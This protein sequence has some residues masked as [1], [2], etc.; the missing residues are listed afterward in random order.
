MD[1]NQINKIYCI[2]I[3]GIGI[4]AA[5]RIL[6]FQ[7]KEVR[8]SDGQA[9]EITDQLQQEGVE[10][11]IGQ[12]VDDL[13][14]E[15]DL[16]VYSVAVP[17]THPQRVKA[18]EIGIRQIT[19]PQLLGL[20]MKDKFGVGVSGTDG[21]TTTTAILGQI[22]LEADLDPTIVIGSKVKY[23]GG[24]SRVGEGQYFLFESDEYQRAFHNYFPKLAI[25]TNLRADHLDCYQDLDDI[26]QAFRIYLDRV[27]DDGLVILNNDDKNLVEVCQNVSARQVTYG[28]DNSAD[29]MAKNILFET[30]SQK[31]NLY[32]HNENL[33]QIVLPRPAKYNV[34]NALAAIAAALDLG[35][36]FERIK[37]S[38]NNFQGVW[39]RFESLGEVNG[40][41]VI[42][43]YAHTPEAVKQTIEATREFYPGKKILIVFQPHQYNRTKNF[44]N[45]FA[46]AFK[47]ADHAIISDIFYVV[48][49]EN[50]ADFEVNSKILAEKSGGNVEYGGDLTQ[51]ESLI[52]KYLPEFDIILIIGAGSIYN[53]AKHL[54]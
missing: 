18:K 2:G 10:V 19:Y 7:G 26:K 47:N 32:R 30:G 42:T 33:G 31:F 28:I 17:E 4:S 20:L 1:L 39:R 21:K 29:L 49:R 45:E 3:G 52:R 27:P 13:N 48:G 8:G 36:G 46:V 16:V 53:L 38:L 50:P 11:T 35:V 25:L 5:A 44:F 54:V 43:D 24:N 23:L 12:S 40:V 15:F 37:S 34:Y 14:S 41:E 22:M 9:S 6:K 51:T